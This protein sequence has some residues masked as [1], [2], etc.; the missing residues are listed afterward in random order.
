MLGGVVFL[1]L[2]LLCVPGWALPPS[3]WEGGPA[4]DEGN[5]KT[6]FE[7]ANRIG[8]DPVAAQP[9]AT[10]AQT[11]LGLERRGLTVREQAAQ[12]GSSN[13][14]FAAPVVRL[15]GRGLDLALN[16][17]YNSR[18]WLKD[19]DHNQ[20]IFD[21]DA[22]WPAPGW[23][24]GFG[25]LWAQ[26][27]TKGDPPLPW[28]VS[29]LFEPDGTRHPSECPGEEKLDGGRIRISC[30]TTDG[31]RIDYSY[32]WSPPGQL[33]YAIAYYPN[34]T[35]VIFGLPGLP[36]RDGPAVIYPTIIMDINTNFIT[37]NYRDYID[38][39]GINRGPAGPEIASIVDTLGRTVTFHYD[40]V[41]GGRLVAITGP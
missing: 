31:S 25:K 35:R 11:S 36:N 1:W 34:G 5:I 39:R 33:I 12:V 40:D 14:Q 8:A 27:W 29:A 22:G 3:Y 13:F 15:P 18:L 37:I 2:M 32:E 16:L 6:A 24:L 21:P 30:Y 38:P 19:K 17:T 10:L 7:P 4:W 23:L 9:P 41:E 20:I 28:K 26:H